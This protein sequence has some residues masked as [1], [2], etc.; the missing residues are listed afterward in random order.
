MSSGCPKRPS[1]IVFRYSGASSGLWTTSAAIGVS[2]TPGATPLTRMPW[3]A[4][5]IA[6]ERMNAQTAAFVTL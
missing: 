6:A 3:R 2:T 1:G 5:S 4:K